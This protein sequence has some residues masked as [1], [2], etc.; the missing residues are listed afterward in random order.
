MHYCA[1]LITNELPTK[2]EIE[3][4]MRPYNWDQIEKDQGYEEDENGV[5][6]KKLIYPV[7]TWDWFQVGGR[8][9]GSLYLDTSEKYKD[10]YNWGYYAKEPRNNRLFISKLLNELQEA[11]R[12][13]GY[14]FFREEDYFNYMG[15]ED[16]KHPKRVIQV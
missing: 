7:F 16:Y 11:K 1:L 14:P 4:I 8:Y 6:N 2:E 10:Y 12:L 9:K 15:F 3:N 13:S 5:G